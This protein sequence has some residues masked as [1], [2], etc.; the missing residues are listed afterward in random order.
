MTGWW[1]RNAAALV[2]VAVLA[3]LSFAA[4]AWEGWQD[5]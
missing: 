4:I 2:A 5:G 3:P 1:R